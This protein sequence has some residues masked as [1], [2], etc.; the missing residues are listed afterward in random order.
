[1]GRFDNVKL[2][3]LLTEALCRHD[4]YST[5]EVVLAGGAQALQL[6]EKQL[7]D[8][9]ML[10][11]AKRLRELCD[12]HDALLMINDRLDIASA[13]GAHGVHLGQDDMS[14]GDA[15]RV[16]GSD[17]IIGL[18][19]HTIEQARAALADPPDY[20]AIGP[21]FPSA[22]KPQG[23]IAGPRTL[24]AV[25]QLT[26]LPLVAIGGITADNAA[27]LRAADTLAVCSA[28]IGAEDTNSAVRKLLATAGQ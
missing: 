17:S 13:A 4:W 27:E 20:L 23:R 8:Q 7:G 3:V 25:R 11:R 6:R 2:Y 9:E 26:S 16:L 5:A 19:T 24:S 28:V 22:T 10:E 15:R 12:C 14:M 21:M 18:S 1:M